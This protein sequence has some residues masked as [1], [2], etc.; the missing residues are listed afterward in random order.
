MICANIFINYLHK[1]TQQTSYKLNIPIYID[2]KTT[3]NCVNCAALMI[4]ELWGKKKKLTS[5]GWS[6]VVLHNKANAIFKV[7]V[8]LKINYLDC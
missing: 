8:S 3:D 5:S 7:F 1:A 4:C 2:K 6:I